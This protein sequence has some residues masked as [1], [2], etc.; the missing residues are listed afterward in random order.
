M[1]HRDKPS[2]SWTELSS[3]REI[4]LYKEAASYLDHVWFGA[5]HGKIYPPGKQGEARLYPRL[6]RNEQKSSSISDEVIEQTLSTLIGYAV[7]GGIY[8]SQLMRGGKQH[9][10]VVQPADDSPEAAIYFTYGVWGRPSWDQRSPVP[11][12]TSFTWLMDRDASL[13]LLSKSGSNP[14]LVRTLFQI[15]MRETAGSILG[16]GE[17][18]GYY[19]GRFHVMEHDSLRTLVFNANEKPSDYR[20]TGNPLSYVLR[21]A[22][23][24]K[25]TRFAG[26]PINFKSPRP[27]TNI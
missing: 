22:V 17:Q 6:Y 11:M 14:D 26:P 12:C 21:S 13:E 8:E 16:M 15:L 25:E 23:I 1:T 3:A 7:M 9:V 4:Q 20:N 2:I 24:D 18:G 19:L 27:V 10:L 5:A